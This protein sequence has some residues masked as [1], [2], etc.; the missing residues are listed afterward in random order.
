MDGGESH[1]TD[2]ELLRHLDA[3]LDHRLEQLAEEAHVRTA[4][5]MEEIARRLEE[6]VVVR[7]KVLLSPAQ[8][9][10]FATMFAAILALIGVVIQGT[11]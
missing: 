6:G 2:A 4:T 3:L 7:H 8:W 11:Q 5:A 1:V 9:A 10:A